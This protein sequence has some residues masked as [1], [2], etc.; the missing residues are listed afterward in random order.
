M[1]E[2]R[3]RPRLSREWLRHP[4]ALLAVAMAVARA[5]F[6]FRRCQQVGARVRL[7]GR[8]WVSNAGTMMIGDRLLMY[9][10]TVRC[11]LSTHSGG[12]LEI[13]RG[14][15]INY[16]ASISAHTLVRIGDGCQIGQYAII[17]DC[18]YHRAGELGAHEAGAPVVLEDGVWLAARVTVLKGVTIGAHAVIGAGSVVTEDIPPRVLAAGVPA[19]VI[20]RTDQDGQSAPGQASH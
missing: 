17:L 3:R 10:G 18:D 20:R 16:G 4:G 6:A 19:R 12:R 9:G 5:R 2:S 13:G 15:F 11:E 14:V 1:L 7:Y 8:C